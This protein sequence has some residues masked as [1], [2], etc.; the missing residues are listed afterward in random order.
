MAEAQEPSSPRSAAPGDQVAPEAPEAPVA[1]SLSA[2]A[3]GQVGRAAVSSLVYMASVL[4]ARVQVEVAQVS[5]TLRC[6][7]ER[8][9]LSSALQLRL[10]RLATTR[11]AAEIPEATGSRTRAVLHRGIEIEGVEM[12]LDVSGTPPPGAAPPAEPTNPRGGGRQGSSAEDD[13][14]YESAEEENYAEREDE[15]LMVGPLAASVAV[16]VGVSSDRRQLSATVGV[17]VPP[18]AVR[19]TNAQVVELT[20][21]SAETEVWEKRQRY[22][23]F[24]PAGWRPPPLDS[25]APSGRRSWRAAW[26]YAF[27]AV[28]HDLREQKGWISPDQLLKYIR[29]RRNYLDMY[30]AK[31]ELESG[32][33]GRG[34]AAREMEEIE[35]T[36]PVETILLCRALCRR[37]ARRTALERGAAAVKAVPGVGALIAGARS[38]GAYLPVDSLRRSF[39]RLTSPRPPDSGRASGLELSRSGPGTPPGGSIGAGAG[40]AGHSPGRA[41]GASGRESE[42]GRRSGSEQGS[43]TAS[44]LDALQAALQNMVAA[45]AGHAKGGGSMK[46][47]AAVDVRVGGVIV[48]LASESASPAPGGG[49]GGGV[50]KVDVGSASCGPTRALVSADD[51][52]TEVAVWVETV[53]V[54]TPSPGHPLLCTPSPTPSAA[55]ASTELVSMGGGGGQSRGGAAVEDFLRERPGFRVPSRPGNPAVA[56]RVAVKRANTAVPGPAHTLP[57]DSS[58]GE[59]S[60]PLRSVS[61][62]SPR[63]RGG[64][65]RGPRLARSITTLPSP[66]AP[67]PA[68]PSPS[69]GPGRG[70]SV[71][72]VMLPGYSPPRSLRTRRS[73]T[74]SMRSAAVE[75]EAGLTTLEDLEDAWLVASQ[76]ALVEPVDMTVD[77]FLPLVRATVRPRLVAP[78]ASFG[79]KCSPLEPY[80]SDMERA[81]LDRIPHPTGHLPEKAR[82]GLRNAVYRHPRVTLHVEGVCASVL[83][84]AGNAVTADVGPVSVSLGVSEY[85][86]LTR[87]AMAPISPASTGLGARATD[88]RASG[89]GGVVGVEGDAR[90]A[91][92]MVQ[93]YPDDPHWQSLALERV[94]WA[95][96]DTRVRVASVDAAVCPKGGPRHALVRL[97]DAKVTAK[98][99]TSGGDPYFGTRAHISLSEGSVDISASAVEQLMGFA[100]NVAAAAVED[101]TVR[102]VVSDG[103]PTFMAG[104]RAKAEALAARMS[105]SALPSAGDTSL[106]LSE[107]RVRALATAAP[108]GPV[109]AQQDPEGRP[110][111]SLVVRGAKMRAALDIFGGN[112]D[113]RAE[114]VSVEDHVTSGDTP[115]PVRPEATLPR[116]LSSLAVSGISASVSEFSELA[117]GMFR[118]GLGISTGRGVIETPAWA[119]PDARPPVVPLAAEVSVGGLGLRGPPGHRGCFVHLGVAPGCTREGGPASPF[120]SASYRMD[121]VLV[122]VSGIKVG[123]GWARVVPTALADGADGWPGLVQRLPLRE[124]ELA[125]MRAIEEAGQHAPPASDKPSGSTV[126]PAHGPPSAP[127]GLPQLPSVR[128]EVRDVML[129]HEVETPPNSCGEAAVV[130][131]DA[132]GLTASDQVAM[133]S[134]ISVEGWSPSSRP[135]DA[136]EQ[137]MADIP[138]GSGGRHVGAAR[139]PV[140]LSATLKRVQVVLPASLLGAAMSLDGR[141]SE[142][143]G[144]SARELLS[145][146]SGSGDSNVAEPAGILVSGVA[147]ELWDVSTRVGKSPVAWLALAGASVTPALP[148][149]GS[150]DQ[151]ASMHMT[152]GDLVAVGSLSSVT[153]VAPSIIRD[154]VGIA[155]TAEESWAR[156]QAAVSEALAVVTPAPGTPPPGEELAAAPGLDSLSVGPSTSSCCETMRTVPVSGVA[157]AVHVSSVS[158]AVEAE[159]AA[160]LQLGSP[161]ED[162]ANGA[163]GVSAWDIEFGAAVCACGGLAADFRA[164]GFRAGVFEG[165]GRSR[166]GRGFVLPGTGGDREIPG[167]PGILCQEKWAMPTREPL[168]FGEAS[169]ATPDAVPS[170]VRDSLGSAGALGLSPP[171]LMEDTPDRFLGGSPWKA[172]NFDL[173][174]GDSDSADERESLS[175]SS[176]PDLLASVTDLRHETASPTG[177]PDSLLDDRPATRRSQ[178]SEA[179]VPNVVSMKTVL[180]MSGSSESPIVALDA[181]RG[182]LRSL[183]GVVGGGTPWP[184]GG[185]YSET[186]DG[187][188]ASAVVG[189]IGVCVDASHLGTAAAAGSLLQSALGDLDASALTVALPGAALGVPEPSDPTPGVQERPAASN[190]AAVSVPLSLAVTL[191]GLSL[192]AVLDVNG[193]E[194]GGCLSLWPADGCT[195]ESAPQWVA[196]ASVSL[197]ARACISASDVGPLLGGCGVAE[198]AISSM[199]PDAA[200]QVG[201]FRSGIG[202]GGPGAAWWTA[203]RASLHPLWGSG[204]EGRVLSISGGNLSAKLTVDPASVGASVEGQL[205]SVEVVPGTSAVTIAAVAAGVVAREILPRCGD[206][207]PGV[208]AHGATTVRAV[209]TRANP[210]AVERT[211]TQPRRVRATAALEGPR[212]AVRLLSDVGPAVVDLLGATVEPPRIRAELREDGSAKLDLSTAARVEMCPDSLLAP[213]PLVVIPSIKVSVLLPESGSPINASMSVPGGV[214]MSFGHGTAKLALGLAAL[215][216][217]LSDAFEGQGH[218]MVGPARV[219]Q[220]K[221]SSST[222]IVV[223]NV[224]GLPIFVKTRDRSTAPVLLAWV[225]SASLPVPRARENVS[226]SITSTWGIEHPRAALVKMTVHRDAPPTIL[227]GFCESR[228]PHLERLRQVPALVVDPSLLGSAPGSARTEWQGRTVVIET[229]LH[230]GLTELVFRSD[231]RVVNTLPRRVRVS[232]GG[233]CRR[234]TIIA[235]LEEAFLPLDAVHYPIHASVLDCPHRGGLHGGI[236]TGNLAETELERPLGSVTRIPVNAVAWPASTGATAALGASDRV[237]LSQSS[238][239]RAGA[240][241]TVWE[242]TATPS[243]A[244]GGGFVVASVVRSASGTTSVVFSS[245]EEVWNCTGAQMEVQGCHV[246][247][248]G[249][250]TVT[251]EAGTGIAVALRGGDGAKLT[252][253]LRTDKGFVPLGG[254]WAGTILRLSRVAEEEGSGTAF[255]PAT[256]LAVWRQRSGGLTGREVHLIAPVAVRSRLPVPVRAGVGRSYEVKPPFRGP[257]VAYTVRSMAPLPPGSTLHLTPPGLDL[258]N[259]EAEL[260][261]ERSGIELLLAECGDE[262]GLVRENSARSATESSAT[263]HVALGRGRGSQMTWVLTEAGALMPVVAVACVAVPALGPPVPRW[264]VALSPAF[265]VNNSSGAPLRVRV[266]TRPSSQSTERR[267]LTSG[268]SPSH[269]GVVV[270][271]PGIEWPLSLPAGS[272]TPPSHVSVALSTSGAAGIGLS[273][274]AV[275]PMTAGFRGCAVLRGEGKALAIAVNVTVANGTAYCAV[276]EFAAFL[277]L[278]VRCSLPGGIVVR[279]RGP[280][281]DDTVPL[282]SGGRCSFA[283]ITSVEIVCPSTGK[284][285][286]TVS[287]ATEGRPRAYLLPDVASPE[288]L[289]FAVVAR[290]GPLTVITL[291][292]SGHRSG[293][294]YPAAP[295]TSVR[296]AATSVAAHVSCEGISVSVSGPRGGLLAVALTGAAATIRVTDM[297][298]EVTFDVSG[299]KILDRVSGGEGVVSMGRNESAMSCRVVI[300]GKAP[301]GVLHVGAAQ[302]GISPI[303]LTVQLPLLLAIAELAVAVADE[304]SGLLAVDGCGATEPALEEPTG[305]FASA[306]TWL[307]LQGVAISEIQVAVSVLMDGGHKTEQLLSD[308]LKQLKVRSGVTRALL[309]RALRG[310]LVCAPAVAEVHEGVIRLPPIRVAD[311]TWSSWDVAGGMAARPGVLSSTVL[312]ACGLAS[313]SGVFLCL[314]DPVKTVSG[315]VVA[316]REVA[317]A[318]CMIDPR[319][320]GQVPGAALRVGKRVMKAAASVPAAAL[321]AVSRA[322]SVAERSLQAAVR[323]YVEDGVGE[324][325]RG[326]SLG[327]AVANGVAGLV[328]AP[329]VGWQRDGVLGAVEGTVAGAAGLALAPAAFFARYTSAVLGAFGQALQG[330]EGR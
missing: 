78:L 323:I 77:V 62:M 55:P 258:A 218:A 154:A 83:D 118:K 125:V 8:L 43:V 128:L 30:S 52:Q 267:D 275:V 290:E 60:S 254:G 20:R 256:V 174:A 205:P 216:A 126:N 283:S 162:C 148:A 158:I 291:S 107:I 242:Q 138:P 69:P 18:I 81:S 167:S 240:G 11:P 17:D 319:K 94:I 56:V 63:R 297:S 79:A 13:E 23:R 181:P 90:Q 145:T 326:K 250:C 91:L 46:A 140:C 321:G 234:R 179:P 102:A 47:S 176:T 201:A 197:G 40:E 220:T 245:P 295:V 59:G 195:A 88:R 87:V 302:I 28:C 301:A 255:P 175:R 49:T 272:E 122:S 313:S 282:V 292:A 15:C 305:V 119:R 113:V 257:G 246:A 104:A 155:V 68:A 261:G 84:P 264:A 5:V 236:G 277:P 157:V 31:L 202:G 72:P 328:R 279:Q 263:R 285:L 215:A 150:P 1:P 293:I 21:I 286:A 221:D 247:A 147:C 116:L 249:K 123:T 112:T 204:D 141:G 97:R 214:D 241:L 135:W 317:D 199:G 200:V 105:T 173:G 133:G 114:L 39:A 54:C 36:L 304:A 61:A 233:E 120:I 45:K 177:F 103:E 273:T 58:P 95:M 66:R 3:L 227:W 137:S 22:G 96:P 243:G 153:T 325:E 219:L 265:L 248:G 303:Q 198:V 213:P 276:A 53:S 329:R 26:Q 252:A 253:T 108:P 196:A 316:L 183:W 309:T 93:L 217:P 115:A 134:P 274:E 65:P 4:L 229:R 89:G 131:M 172:I 314:G 169:H 64:T 101:G 99:P 312:S 109:S 207:T 170:L 209:Q 70:G 266:L 2:Q 121:D 38:I 184:L 211:A 238:A 186:T 34:W 42:S 299:I 166:P 25:P 296:W 191:E 189:N 32:G 110:L 322:A 35:Q 269:D 268:P 24:R 222:R 82:R 226:V 231:L 80:L 160:V 178:S 212:V 7:D 111:W 239:V 308:T 225:G 230:A 33:A 194:A 151:S 235:P 228:P 144:K 210:E 124:L 71:T 41:P 156:F 159:S 106:T 50:V 130:D 320:P 164:G 251:T 270:V 310:G 161:A 117:A 271:P 6:T 300:G 185:G 318:V 57:T 223:T 171:V 280:L 192:G 180:G 146:L 208:S 27:R 14:G 327:G 244:D 149:A 136:S 142:G 139:P 67:P 224:T 307:W 259:L 289:A 48:T 330:G 311:A 73:A 306:P 287:T 129:E 288:G 324:G 168:M 152:V 187:V 37:Q 86:A 203:C 98:V 294:S 206:D 16:R 44:D 193:A 132:S 51:E 100:A 315:V 232:S 281:K 76:P 165:R 163:F 92:R 12:G 237:G 143:T 85:Y 260:L 262:A 74:G 188:N 19:V 127:P 75:S 9:G 29:L 298:T 278:E 182:T 10:G 284:A 190:P